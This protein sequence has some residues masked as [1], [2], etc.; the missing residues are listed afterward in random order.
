MVRGV[1]VA[2]TAAVAK[3]TAWTVA[4]AVS[5]ARMAV[6]LKAVRNVANIIVELCFIFQ[7]TL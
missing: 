6:A 2:R 3:T 7:P 4:K 5:V 1:S